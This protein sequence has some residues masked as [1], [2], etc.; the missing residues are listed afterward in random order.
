MDAVLSKGSPEEAGLT[1][2]GL[3]R[4]D[5]ALADLVAAKELAGV[6][7]LVA[8]HGKVVHRSAIGVKDV[9]SGEALA[10]DTIFR[11]YSMT[12]PVTAVAMMILHDQ[13]LWSPDDPIVKHLPEFAEVKV[14]GGAAPDHA[15]TLRELMTH[16]AGLGYGFD[17]NDATDAA[18]I[19]AGVW[20]AENLAEMTRRLATAPLAYQPGSRWRYSMSMDVQGAIIEKLSG[21]SLPDFMRS[22]IFQPLGMVDTDFYVPTAKLPRLATLYRWSKS[23]GLV[24]SE[25][26]QGRHADRIPKLAGGGGGLFS[27][28]ADYARF[29]QMLLNKGELGGVRVISPQA[30]ALMTANHLSDAIIASDPSVGLQKIRPGFG[31]GFNGA[32]YY[33]PALAGSKVGR[34]SYQWDGAAGTWF[35]IDPENDLLYVGLIQRMSPDGGPHMHKITQDLIADALA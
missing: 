34:G 27:T 10:H 9:E 25:P 17:P 16:T 5:Q 29:A 22:K 1:T 4:V 35:W 26:L 7:T 24:V 32:A 30:V 2:A 14:L 12:K 19:A 28:A 11:I 21:Q 20:Q 33:D 6:V 31:Y 8:R 3:A 23:R 15:P 18:Y 13:G